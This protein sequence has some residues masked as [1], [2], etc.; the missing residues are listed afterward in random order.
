MPVEGGGVSLFVANADG[1]GLR[2]VTPNA[3]DEGD[4]LLS[5]D[6]S[7]DG[8]TIVVADQLSG[9]DADRS[10]LATFP[11]DGSPGSLLVGLD[12]WWVVQ[13]PA[14]SP[15]GKRIAFAGSARGP[16]GIYVFDLET[17][18]A[19]LV[20]GTDELSVGDPAWSPDG[21]RIVFEA[22]ADSDTDPG[23]TWDI[24]SVRL[25][26]SGLTNLTDTPSQTE[27]SPAWSWATDRIAFV[28]GG[29]A[30]PG[31]FTIAPDGTSESLV[32]FQGMAIAKPAWSPDGR[33]IAFSA[34]EGRIYTIPASGGDPTVVAGAFGEPAWQAVPEGEAPPVP[35]P[36]PQ[37]SAATTGSMGPDWY[38]IGLGYPFAT[39]RRLTADSAPA[40]RGRRT[41]PRR[42]ATPVLAIRN[43]AK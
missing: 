42:L 22:S 11:I 3:G 2:E 15:D 6:V 31:L 20:P 35:S 25:D 29:D 7:P 5:P 23:Q 14:W 4:V 8:R 33:S 21:T 43:R 41:S 26:G 24:Y 37:T 18:R 19:R 28:R 12:E 30:A 17:G 16:F 36:S 38:D 13:D 9:F 1:S 34:D 10:F 40:S 27:M 32:T 39:R